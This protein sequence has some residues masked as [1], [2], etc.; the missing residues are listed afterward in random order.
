VTKLRIWSESKQGLEVFDV[1]VSVL[2]PF[3][4]LSFFF[5]EN[6]GALLPSDKNKQQRFTRVQKKLA[7]S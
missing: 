4:E 6:R 1:L 2:T 5:E 3:T 7:R